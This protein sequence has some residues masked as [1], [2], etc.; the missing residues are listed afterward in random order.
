MYF[1]EQ[2]SISTK[3]THYFQLLLSLSSTWHSVW[4]LLNHGLNLWLTTWGERW[5][6]RRGTG[7]CNFTWV[8]GRGGARLLPSESPFKGCL[9]RRKVLYLEIT[10]FGAL[11]QAQDRGKLFISLLLCKCSNLSGSIP[12]YLTI[13]IPVCHTHGITLWPV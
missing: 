3:K 2:K 4:E 13:C 10:P 5:V 11:L 9:P 8:T 1:N 7:K 6:S 12:I